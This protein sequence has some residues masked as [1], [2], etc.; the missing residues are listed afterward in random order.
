M[1]PGRRADRTR[2]AGSAI[3]W[4]V[5]REAAA[6]PV[7]E[8]VFRAPGFELLAGHIARLRRSDI[9][10]LGSPSRANVEYLSQ[11]SCVLH[12]GD[13]SRALAE[14]PEMAVPEEERDVEGAV[15]RAIAFQDHTRL[16]AIFAWDLFDYLDEATS[17]AIMRR[18]GGYCCTGT[19]LYL[20]TSTG[21]TI[22][23]RPGRFTIVDE[24]NL[25]VERVG[26]GTRSGMKHSP[27]G[28]ER[29]MP[30]FR[31]HHSFLLGHQMQDYLFIH[32]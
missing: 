16:N 18:I 2:S 21:E 15:E 22:P 14:D 30:G 7:P 8:R 24:R 1:I 12:I 17:R 29:I 27:R 10:D 31:L 28:L 5:I 9:F 13:V 25:R 23:D 19:L 20:T 3:P 6:P 32:Q 26:A 4:P 11:F